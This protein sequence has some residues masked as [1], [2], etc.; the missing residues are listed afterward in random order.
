MNRKDINTIGSFLEGTLLF[1][2]IP[3]ENIVRVIEENPDG[4]RHYSKGE[5]ILREG[6][7]AGSIRLILSGNVISSRTDIEGDMTVYKR[8]GKGQMISW[9]AICQDNCKSELDYIADE[10]TDIFVIGD[11]TLKDADIIGDSGF[12]QVLNNIINM[13]THENNCQNK[14]LRILSMN[15]I[16]KK[17]MMY[18]GYEYEKQGTERIEISFNRETLAAYLCVNRSALS[19]ELGKM[20][21]EGLVKINGKKFVLLKPEQ[22]RIMS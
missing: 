12:N 18:L 9:E 21:E 15:T 2:D 20:E 4:Q 1:M 6:E 7:P 19:R 17:V 22:F 3:K 14:K 8:L 10:E 5:Y 16:R 11:D 13:N